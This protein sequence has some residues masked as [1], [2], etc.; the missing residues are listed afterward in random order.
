[1]KNKKELQR[2]PPKQLQNC[3]KYIT[4]H[5]YFKCKWTNY[6]NQKTQS[7]QIGMKTKPIDMLL[8]RD[9]L[10]I[11]DTQKLKIRG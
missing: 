2:N 1:M 5:N 3:N 8:A 7:G 6:S 11:K 4:I 9:S 10:Q